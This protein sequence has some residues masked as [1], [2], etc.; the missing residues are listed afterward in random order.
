MVL[1]SATES[2][3]RRVNVLFKHAFIFSSHPKLAFFSNLLLLSIRFIHYPPTALEMAA[4]PIKIGV[5]GCANIAR[6]V[7]RAIILSPNS[8]LYAIGSRSS[9]KAS[10]FALEN[11]FPDSAKV[12]G[13]YDAVLD[14]P[15]VD[16]VYIPLPTSLHVHWAV[17]A[18]LKK[19][20]LLLEKP[21]ALNVKELDIILEACESGGVQ[22]MDGTMWMHNPRTFKMKE[23]LSDSSLFGELKS[24]R[25]FS[26]LSN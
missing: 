7:S 14:D 6:K 8:V 18:A 2:R 24:V 9:E 4:P 17:R 22:I 21:V 3:N 1:E 12:F 10:K 19:K 13:S 15:E 23:F 5:L 26:T 25:S 16:A 11:G 20:H